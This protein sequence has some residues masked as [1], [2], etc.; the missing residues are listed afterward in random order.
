MKDMYLGLPLD[1]WKDNCDLAQDL[2][3]EKNLGQHILGIYPYGKRIYGYESEKLELFCIYLDSVEAILDPYT[4]NKTYT[5]IEINPSSTST[6]FFQELRTWVSWTGDSVVSEDHIIPCFYDHLYEDESLTE[7]ITFLQELIL[8][9]KK[10]IPQ[11]DCFL[12]WR[13]AYIFNKLKRYEPNVNPEWGDVFDFSELNFSHPQALHKIEEKILKEE[14][15]YTSNIIK[16][17]FY[18]EIKELKKEKE[19]ELDIRDQVSNLVINL[20]RALV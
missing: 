8:Q 16:A 12:D 7:I 13:A 6:I 3:L 11:S 1:T 9:Y 15:N 19:G 5:P 14:A 17:I 18:N 20:Y 2:L 10:Y 4:L